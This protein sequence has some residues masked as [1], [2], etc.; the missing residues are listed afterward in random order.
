MVS[1]QNQ[2]SKLQILVEQLEQ[3]ELSFEESMSLYK[4]GIALSEECSKKLTKA[5]RE[6]CVLQSSSNS[7]KS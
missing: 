4:K 3:D 2:L 6:I 1:L 7:L 5:Q